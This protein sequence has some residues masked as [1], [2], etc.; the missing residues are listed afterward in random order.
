MK[1]GK[2][3]KLKNMKYEEALQQLEEIVTK[4]EAGEL[5]IDDLSAKLKQ[6]QQLIKLC[7]DKLTAA[8]TEIKAILDDNA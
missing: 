7:K 3:V 4:L 8:D 2:I 5:D 6:A 1:N